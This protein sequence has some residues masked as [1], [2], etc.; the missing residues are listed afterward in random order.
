MSADKLREEIKAFNDKRDAVLLKGDLDEV[1]ALSS[2][3]TNGKMKPTSREVTEI[4]LHKCRTAVK[5]LPI[6]LRQASKKWLLDRGMKFFDD[7]DV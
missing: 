4:M 6:E 3:N 2:E 1:E 5:S 7:G